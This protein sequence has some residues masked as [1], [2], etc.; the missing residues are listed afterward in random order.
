MADNIKNRKFIPYKLTPT[1]TIKI[2]AKALTEIKKQALEEY[3]IQGVKEYFGDNIQER[4]LS[5]SIKKAPLLKVPNAVVLVSFSNNP[6]INP[7]SLNIIGLARILVKS[8]N[9]DLAPIPVIYLW[10]NRSR[11]TLKHEKI[12]ICQYLQDRA[13]PMT[14]GQKELFLSRSLE[15][16]VDYLLGKTGKDAATDFIINAACYKTWIEMEANY[17]TRKPITPEVWMMK[18]YNS[19][20]PIV[21][22]NI[23]SQIIGWDNKDMDRVREKFD[24]FCSSMEKE[25][26]WVSDL[27]RSSSASSLHEL[28][29]HTHEEYE[30]EMM[31]GPIS[32]NEEI[33]SNEFIDNNFFEEDD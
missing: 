24:S 9:G 7:D 21:T 16:G 29:F 11:D 28:I 20:L 18:V 22:F 19:S 17:Y 2:V 8:Q 25:V 14:P 13:Y 31:F 1:H 30:I 15:E 32:E 23:C 10:P 3:V 33:L 6:L 26:K 12:H 4:F 27:V 5:C